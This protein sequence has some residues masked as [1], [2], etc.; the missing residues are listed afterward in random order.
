MSAQARNVYLTVS[1]QPVI[2]KMKFESIVAVVHMF[3][4]GHYHQG[5]KMI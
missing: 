3:G 2:I 1:V 5:I 4:R